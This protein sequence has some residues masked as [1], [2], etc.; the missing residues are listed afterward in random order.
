MVC[1]SVLDVLTAMS[2]QA[3]QFAVSLAFY[4]GALAASLARCSVDAATAPARNYY[5]KR[6]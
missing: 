5:G 4:D 3:G 6:W 2:A 1:S